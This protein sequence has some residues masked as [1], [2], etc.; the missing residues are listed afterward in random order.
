STPLRLRRTLRTLCHR[1]SGTGG[2]TDGGAGASGEGYGYRGSRNRPGN[3]TGAGDDS[4]AGRGTPDLEV[5][6]GR[7][8][9]M[10][11]EIAVIGAGMHPWG[12]WGRNFVEYGVHAARA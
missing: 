5:A 11:N 4:G 12:K 3:G 10:S 8:C 6:S 1:R 2:G 7:R 9:E